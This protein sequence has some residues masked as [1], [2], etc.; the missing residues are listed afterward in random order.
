MVNKDGTQEI[1]MGQRKK[2]RDNGNK[3]GKKKKRMGQRISE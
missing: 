3:Y 1:R 2:G